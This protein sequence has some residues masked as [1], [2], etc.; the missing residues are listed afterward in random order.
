MDTARAIACRWTCC[1]ITLR[2]C[3]IKRYRRYSTA[4]NPSPRI[5][6]PG[7]Q[8]RPNAQAYVANE[9]ASKTNKMYVLFTVDF[10]CQDI[11]SK[12]KYLLKNVF[13]KV[14]FFRRYC[15]AVKKHRT[16]AL[17]GAL[18]VL[19]S[20]PWPCHLSDYTL[21]S[22]TLTHNIWPQS[23]RPTWIL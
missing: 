2:L 7:S 6:F 16:C 23:R 20:Y 15:L 13:F 18:N 12:K 1:A 10:Y 8:Y 5:L 11:S 9:H 22:M 3:V 19:I 17:N 21:W 14:T 4:H